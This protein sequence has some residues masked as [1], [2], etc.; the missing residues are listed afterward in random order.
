[1]NIVVFGANGR[2][3]QK[4]V[5]KLLAAQ[6]SVRAVVHGDDPFEPNKQLEVM[7]GDI[8]DGDFVAN[9]VAGCDAVASTLGSW[10]T[11]TKDIQVAGMTNIIPA[12]QAADITRI[13][14]LTGAGVFDEPDHPSPLDKFNRLLMSKGAHRVFRDGEKHIRLLRRS[15]LNWTVI[16]SPIMKEDG[17]PGHYVLNDRFPA[18]WATI[19]RDDVADAICQLVV[20]EDWAQHAPFIHRAQ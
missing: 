13:I 20:S 5:K 12:M 9:A 15:H 14:S 8:H 4:V 18:P 16:R 3:G 2:V 11:A 7:Q 6:H 17:E 1:M 10:G 19:V